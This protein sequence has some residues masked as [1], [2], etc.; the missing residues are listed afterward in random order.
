MAWLFGRS[1]RFNSLRSSAI[2]TRQEAAAGK[3]AEEDAHTEEQKPWH[4]YR[5]SIE[6]YFKPDEEEFGDVLSGS[7]ESIKSSIR[8]L[9]R[10]GKKALAVDL[11]GNASGWSLGA[12][13]TICLSLAKESYDDSRK[14]IVDGNGFEEH[15]QLRLLEQIDAYDGELMLVTFCPVG[16]I[17]KSLLEEDDSGYRSQQLLRLFEKVYERLSAQGKFFISLSSIPDKETV[18]FMQ[19][20]EEKNIPYEYDESLQSM[21][22]QGPDK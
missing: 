16:G 22:L 9:H 10:S 3:K 5:S 18:Q 14:V 20:L 11:F 8:E 15:I 21:V 2:Q 17:K 6:D 19:Y 12:D 13:K 4:V 7:V 1:D